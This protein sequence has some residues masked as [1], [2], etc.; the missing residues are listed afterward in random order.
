MNYGCK[1]AMANGYVK[2]L[3]DTKAALSS[4]SFYPYEVNTQS[5]GGLFLKKRLVLAVLEKTQSWIGLVCIVLRQYP[6]KASVKVWYGMVW[7]E[8]T[9]ILSFYESESSDLI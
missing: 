8:T 7:F 5:G 3:V 4:E 1:G 9:S 6:S 2:W